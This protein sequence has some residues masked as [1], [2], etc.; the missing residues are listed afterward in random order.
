MKMRALLLVAALTL[1]GC[2]MPAMRPEVATDFRQSKLA[3]AVYLESK[4]IV[5]NE[6][7]YKVLWNET[8]QNISSFDGLWDVDTDLSEQL[9]ADMKGLELQAQPIR[10]V[11]TSDADYEA[12]EKSIRATVG[13]GLAEV[14]L[15]LD[16]AVLG[17]FRK[18]GISYLVVLRAGGFNIS[19]TTMN[20]SGGLNLPAVLFVYDIKQNKQEY[21][22][23]MFSSEFV[24]WGKTPRN[25]EANGMEKVKEA[26]SKMIKT[27]IDNNLP[28]VLGIA[29][30]D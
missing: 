19:T 5:Y 7:V 17:K 11:L 21:R 2:A 1:A 12:L 9:A 8:R 6:M 28:K 20:S 22:E 23:A 18:A 24:T 15:Q 3:A 16:E 13:P 25:I 30:A 10:T 27:S 4:T 14:P 26:A 29:Q